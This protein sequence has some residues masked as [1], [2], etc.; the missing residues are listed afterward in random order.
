MIDGFGRTISYVRLSVTD[1]CDLRCRYCMPAKMQFVPRDRLLAL[2]EFVALADI[3]IAKGVKRIRLSGGEP[4]VRKGIEELVSIL[5]RK[6]GSGLDE[7]T[8]TTN[9][10]H[11]RRFADCLAAAGIARINVSL[12]SLDPDMFRHLTRGGD[13]GRVL[14]G[15]QAAVEAGLKVKINTVGLRGL[16][17]NEIPRMLEWCGAEGHDL[18]LIEAMPLG[19]V[20]A[21]RSA[22]YLPLG[23]VREQLQHRF[24]LVPS[25]ARTGGPARYY[26]VPS[27]GMRLGLITPLTQNFCEGCNRIRIAA[28]GTVSTLR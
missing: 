8:M 14:D 28:T 6:I 4:L 13:L 1:R 11:L 9:G 7:L 26:E 23:P 2:E 20:E 24:G 19:E 16:N 15:I 10:M 12:D 17:E 21:D 18:T 3:L 27:L 5:G 25:V 22:H